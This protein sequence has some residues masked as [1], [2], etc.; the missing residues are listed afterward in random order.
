MAVG[1]TAQWP[2]AAHSKFKGHLLCYYKGQVHTSG[3]ILYR[4]ELTQSTQV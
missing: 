4:D 2:P 1:S 3:T